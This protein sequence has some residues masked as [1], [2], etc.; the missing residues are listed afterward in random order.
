MSMEVVEEFERE[1]WND[2]DIIF[3]MSEEEPPYNLYYIYQKLVTSR[4]IQRR[5]KLIRK[6]LKYLH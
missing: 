2:P 6:Y 4:K 3:K 5:L 1:F